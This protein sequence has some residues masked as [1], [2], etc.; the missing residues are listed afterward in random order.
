V[1]LE[2]LFHEPLCGLGI[3]LSLDEEVQDFPLLF[4]RTPKPKARAPD[5]DRRV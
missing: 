5:E 3:P 2:H 1:L 4:H